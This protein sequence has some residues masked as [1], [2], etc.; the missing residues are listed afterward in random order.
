MFANGK[1]IIGVDSG[2]YE[3]VI[4]F[5]HAHQWEKIKHEPA[6][7]RDWFKTQSTDEVVFACESTQDLFSQMAIEKGFEVY[8][9]TPLQASYIRKAM[10]I[11]GKKDDRNDALVHARALELNAEMF[12][13]IEPLD[14]NIE[15]LR[16]LVNWRERLV[17]R[18]VASENRLRDLLKDVFPGLHQIRVN[19]DA[20]WVLRLLMESPTSN[21]F[22]DYENNSTL[23]RLSDL[24]KIDIDKVK[25]VLSPYKMPATKCFVL[26]G[27][28]LGRLACKTLELVQEINEHGREI[29]TILSEIES[30]QKKENELGPIEI[31]RSFPRMGPLTLARIIAEY[32]EI[33]TSP[34]PKALCAY[35]GATPV[36]KQSGRSR[37]VHRRYSRNKRLQSALCLLAKN[38]LR[39]DKK[40]KA[41][42]ARHRSKGKK[43]FGAY[44][45]MTP[46]IINTLCAMLRTG[47]VYEPAF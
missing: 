38:T 8:S 4:Y 34:D 46:N 23:K 20:Q 39:G 16:F 43:E 5:N 33:L 10:F 41:L 14:D 25:E 24:L 21:C 45:A 35:A 13:K 15:A 30:A 26:K 11:S 42:F 6:L 3:S 17:A 28:I 40:M 44:R 31:L 36:T 29:E 22:G 32:P 1:K 47:T 2:R 19:L 18:R 27:R 7:V 9:T 12:R 37:V